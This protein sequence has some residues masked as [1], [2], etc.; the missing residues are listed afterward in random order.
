MPPRSGTPFEHFVRHV[1][2]GTRP[3]ENLA[4]GLDL[5]RLME[6]AMEGGT[7]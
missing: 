5:T 1:A 4:L 2:E 3:D 7:V 6:A